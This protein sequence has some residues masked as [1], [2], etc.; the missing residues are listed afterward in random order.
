MRA[1]DS[2]R[3]DSLAESLVRSAVSAVSIDV[4]SSRISLVGSSYR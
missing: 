3:P 1:A 4:S 2:V